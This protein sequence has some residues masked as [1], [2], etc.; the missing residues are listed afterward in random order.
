MHMVQLLAV[1]DQVVGF[2]SLRRPVH[3][4]VPHDQ[5]AVGGGQ[6]PAGGR[7]RC[8]QCLRQQGVEDEHPARCQVPRR[9]F[10][11]AQLC[12]LRGD[13][14]E[15][16]AREVDQRVAAVDWYLGEVADRQPDVLATWPGEQFGGHRL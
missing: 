14:E 5:R 3:L 10:E 4:P 11:A 1:S 15:C 2:V 16:S 12:F 13:F 7:L 9:R 6:Y 8:G